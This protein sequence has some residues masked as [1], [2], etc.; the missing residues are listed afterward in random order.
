VDSILTLPTSNPGITSRPLHTANTPL[1]SHLA[2]S[3]VRFSSHSSEK[4][5]FFIPKARHF[6]RIHVVEKTITV[7]G[8]KLIR[9]DYCAPKAQSQGE[10]QGQNNRVN[11]SY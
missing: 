9:F 8:V 5:I 3:S 4:E 2:L 10:P 1:L 7:Y 11:K 6:W